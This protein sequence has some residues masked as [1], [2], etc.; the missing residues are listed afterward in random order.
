MRST[1]FSSGMAKNVERIYYKE[2]FRRAHHTEPGA[3][4]DINNVADFYREGFL[5]ALD[6]EK[7]KKAAWTV[8][9]D[10]NY[11]PSSQILPLLLNEL[12]CNVIALNAYVDEGRGSKKD[13]DRQ[14][15]RGGRVV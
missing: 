1:F 5:R 9:I 12:G 14:E 11:S 8:V 3:I 6:K 10:F 4:I 2:N 13:M 15:G 7:L